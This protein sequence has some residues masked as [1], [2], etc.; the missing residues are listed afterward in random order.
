MY[1]QWGSVGSAGACKYLVYHVQQWSLSDT[2]CILD[3]WH[4][5]HV[6]CQLFSFVIFTDIDIFVRS[7]NHFCLSWLGYFPYLPECVRKIP[8]IST[9][10]VKT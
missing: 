9:L 5:V 10:F 3:T 2:M 6:A 1:M 7:Y 8:G 4:A